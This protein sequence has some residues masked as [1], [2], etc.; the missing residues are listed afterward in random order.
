MPPPV[1]WH[2][3]KRQQPSVEYILFYWSVSS[4]YQHMKLL[5]LDH[6]G[7]SPRWVVNNKI[8]ASK[9]VS[10]HRIWECANFSF[11]SFEIVVISFVLQDWGFILHFGPLPDGPLCRTFVS[12]KEGAYCKLMTQGRDQSYERWGRWQYS[13]TDDAVLAGH[14]TP[15]DTSRVVVVGTVVST[16]NCQGV[17]VPPWVL[18]GRSLRY[19]VTYSGHFHVLELKFYFIFFCTSLH[20]FSCSFH[21]KIQSQDRIMILHQLLCQ[22]GKF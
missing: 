20:S 22:V 9:H 7:Q 19:H 4:R 21:S 3:G 2:F 10:L 6:W 14:T 1:L 8:L 17:R 11:I 13:G 18:E 12:A 16:V 5:G 15:N